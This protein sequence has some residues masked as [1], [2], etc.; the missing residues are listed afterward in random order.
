MI[1]ILSTFNGETRLRDML[2][3]M[4]RVRITSG[5]RFHVVDNASTDGTRA[6]LAEYES[7]LPL[8]IYNQ[9]VRGKNHCLNLALNAVA[10]ELEP[11]ELVVLTDDDI[12]PSAE[13]LDE[14]QAAANA[15][16]DCDIFAGRILPHWPSNFS[17]RIE[18]VRRHFGILFSLTS[19]VEGP[20]D[21]AE[22]WGP[23]MAVRGHVFKSGIRFDPRF[24]PNSTIGY[25][26]GSETE[27]M[28]RLDSAGYRAWFV[29]RACVRHMI[30]A[31]QLDTTSIVQRAFR[32]GYGVG[33]R[34]QR[35]RGS[36]RLLMSLGNALRGLVAAQVRH[37]WTSE[38]DLLLQDYHEA[39][40]RGLASGALFEYR[41]SRRVPSAA[42]LFPERGEEFPVKA[43]D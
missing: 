35:G 23:N 30:R 40:A 43:R 8:V 16:P 22:A 1:V 27:M 29:E 3:A 42:E 9:P 2:E 18:P 10:H 20:C 31:S 21:A 19:H 26:M 34:R 7:K 38:A 5:A 24:G 11:D 33:W 17:P 28:E 12:L 15:H 6:V 14:M 32:H 13:W 4:I 41:R 25:P 37:L 39:W 36:L